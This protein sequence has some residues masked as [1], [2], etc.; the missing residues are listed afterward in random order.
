MKNSE[1]YSFDD[2]CSDFDFKIVLIGKEKV[3]KTCITNR[4]VNETFNDKHIQTKAVHTQKKVV[5]IPGT[6]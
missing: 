2:E 4:Y 1:A 6:D 3:G 5:M